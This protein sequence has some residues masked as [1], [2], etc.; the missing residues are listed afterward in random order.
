MS[1][2]ARIKVPQGCVCCPACLAV[3]A[4]LPHGSTWSVVRCD[5]CGHHFA[6]SSGEKVLLAS[7]DPDGM[8]EDWRHVAKTADTYALFVAGER[9]GSVAW[10]HYFDPPVSAIRGPKL[11]D[12]RS[13]RKSLDSMR[14]GRAWVR[15][16]LAG[17]AG[18]ERS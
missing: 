3:S 7:Y 2:D 10:S 12:D 6:R 18:K 15:A 5:D 11:L 17:S 13:N 16:G 14:E 4:P 8:G 1:A 9:A